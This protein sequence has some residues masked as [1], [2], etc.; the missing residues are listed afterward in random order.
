[1]KVKRNWRLVIT[2][3]CIFAAL[4]M[5][6]LCHFAASPFQLLPKSFRY[7]AYA[8]SAQS[9]E[10]DMRP[11]DLVICDKNI[12]DFS[13]GAIVLYRPHM[14]S[15]SI[16]AT[17]TGATFGRVV[18]HEPLRGDIMDIYTV[19]I[20]MNGQ[21]ISAMSRRPELAIYRL[22]G[23]GSVVMTLH[24]VRY[25]VWGV[26]GGIALGAV[27]WLAFTAKARRIRRS[28]E[29]YLALFDGFYRE[30]EKDE[31]DF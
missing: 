17:D 15:S 13:T 29:A 14:F 6:L 5:L 28:R 20:N 9:F 12:V 22:N 16:Y 23:L 4:I 21:S 1:M 3:L 31:T 24:A 18:A 2:A 26:C 25:L 8:V 27:L 7:G 19:Q 30:V 11:G 10:G